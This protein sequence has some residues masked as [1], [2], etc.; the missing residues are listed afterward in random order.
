MS[1]SL[2]NVFPNQQ[3][4]FQIMPQLLNFIDVGIEL[5]SIDWGVLVV[6]T[7]KSSCDQGPAYKEEFIIKQDLSS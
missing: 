3:I 4:L 1:S 5:N 7:C 6:Y 2:T